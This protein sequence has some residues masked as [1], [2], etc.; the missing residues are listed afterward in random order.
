MEGRA[1]DMLLDW[2]GRF[3]DYF[4]ERGLGWLVRSRAWRNKVLM[5]AWRLTFSRAAETIMILC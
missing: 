5:T 4:C 1:V 3:L 2:L